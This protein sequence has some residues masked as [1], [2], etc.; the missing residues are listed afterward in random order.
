[1]SITRIPGDP[2][3]EV[4]LRR[5]ARARRYSLRVSQL[6]GRVTLT[7]PQRAPEADG[8]AF[9]REKEAWIRRH[10]SARPE[11][12]VVRAGGTVPYEGRALALVPGSGRAPRLHEGTLAVPG[13]AAEVP[14]RVQAFLKTRARAR[15]AAA[16]DGYTAA[17]GLSY[18]RL[19]LR[20][21]RSRWG[22]CSSRGDLM[23]AWRLIMAPPEVLDYVA[24]HEVAHLVEM[25]HSP[26]FWAVV[27]RL[28][29]G[30]E[31]PRAWLRANG[32]ALHRVRFGD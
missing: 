27:A 2:P 24:A 31:A 8:L 18:R 26:A 32:A 16:A 10:L 5:S 29:P 23:F 11:D 1:M 7:L 6:D 3:L 19:T 13:P 25:N 14:A 15:L 21:A 20:D 9:V 28:M 4:T 30:Y 12:Q 22:S 17:L